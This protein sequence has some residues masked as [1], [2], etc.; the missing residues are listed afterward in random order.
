MPPATRGRSPQVPFPAPRADGTIIRPNPPRRKASFTTGRIRY[1]TDRV[2]P[3]T[4]GVRAL[5]R[6]AACA[7]ASGLRLPPSARADRGRLLA[8]ARERPLSRA[9]RSSGRPDLNRGP[10][11]RYG[12]LR[13]S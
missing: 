6:R 4:G 1:P 13:V 10:P 8:V 7:L 5:G 11:V 12:Q 2:V 9:F 3:S